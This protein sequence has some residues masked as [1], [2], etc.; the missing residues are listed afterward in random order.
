MHPE[1]S[2]IY[3]DMAGSLLVWIPTPKHTI[4][5]LE[6]PIFPFNSYSPVEISKMGIIKLYSSMKQRLISLIDLN[7][8]NPPE[9]VCL[10]SMYTTRTP[11]D[12]DSGVDFDFVR[13]TGTP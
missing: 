13:I 8:V 11:T 10:T 6:R 7:P 9:S 4:I 12:D 3:V 5:A 2:L 1:S